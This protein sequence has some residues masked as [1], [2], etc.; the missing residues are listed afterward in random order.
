MISRPIGGTD[1]GEYLLDEFGKLLEFETVKDAIQFFAERNF[2]ITDLLDFDFHFEELEESPYL[3]T[4]RE[5]EE[6]IA[7]YQRRR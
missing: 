7:A 3:L 5:C 2:T 6:A 1:G 4:T